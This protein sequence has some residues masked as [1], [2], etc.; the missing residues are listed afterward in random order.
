MTPAQLMEYCASHGIDPETLQ[1]DDFADPIAQQS[2]LAIDGAGGSAT[3][4]PRP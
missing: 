1:D 4:P 2:Q 3:L